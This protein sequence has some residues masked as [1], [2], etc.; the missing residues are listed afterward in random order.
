M[1]A[2]AKTLQQLFAAIDGDGTVV[3]RRRRLAHARVGTEARCP[4]RLR[5]RGG[6]KDAL[7]NYQYTS[8]SR[9]Y[10]VVTMCQI[11]QVE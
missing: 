8:D 4:H 3:L 2:H 1:Q 5:F 7:S 9:T 6:R 11:E 10:F